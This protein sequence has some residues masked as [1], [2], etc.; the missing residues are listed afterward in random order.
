MVQCSVSLEGAVS[1]HPFSEQ[2]GELQPLYILWEDDYDDDDDDD[3]DED[4]DQ[5]HG[6]G[7]IDCK[8]FGSHQSEEQEE[9]D[10]WKL[11]T[12]ILLFE[13]RQTLDSDE[14]ENSYFGTTGKP[15]K[16][17]HRPVYSLAVS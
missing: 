4:D 6:D 8:E 5:R 1:C 13:Q 15:S 7:V 9:M 10:L 14:N 2:Q 11:S 3:D 16:T 12:L 17:S